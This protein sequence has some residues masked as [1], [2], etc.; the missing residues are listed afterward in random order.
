MLGTLV[1]LALVVIT[2]GTSQPVLAVISGSMEPEMYRGTLIAIHN[3]TDPRDGDIVVFD[4]DGRT[5][6]I[7]H[8]IT[9]HVKADCVRTKGDNNL[10]DDLFLYN[11][12]QTCVDRAHIRGVV[13]LNVPFL[14]WP[15][16]L[17]SGTVGKLAMSAL[18][19]FSSRSDVRAIYALIKKGELK[20]ALVYFIWM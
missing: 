11:R 3:W 2:S 19:L 4:V 8:R 10:V 9:H 12:G 5:E 14:G 15:A 13:W 20:K 18:V 7:V 16:I 6:P 17:V 1:F